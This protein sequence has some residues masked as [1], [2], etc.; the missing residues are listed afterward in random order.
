MSGKNKV[1]EDK[2]ETKKKKRRGKGC[3]EKRRVSCEG[4]MNC[5]YLAGNFANVF[6]PCQGNAF[7]NYLAFQVNEN[8]GGVLR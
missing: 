5:L 7:V 8:N 2:T 4:K 3:G 6:W 1:G